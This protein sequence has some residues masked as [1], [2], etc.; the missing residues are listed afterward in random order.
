MSL[1]KEF[2][3]KLKALRKHRNMTQ[4]QLAEI[5]NVDSRHISY[6]E[7]AKSFP[8]CELIE[9]LCK[10]FN[11][12]YSELFNFENTYTRDELLYNLNEIIQTL[13]DKKL[14]YIYK[15]SLEL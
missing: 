7:T 3:K 1:K 4:E 5:V 8:S 15:M 14:F 9:R 10:A 2:A 12:T 6:L 11:V 13:D